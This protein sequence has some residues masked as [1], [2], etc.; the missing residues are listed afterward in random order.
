MIF[1]LKGIYALTIVVMLIFGVMKVSFFFVID[2]C[3]FCLQKQPHKRTYLPYLMTEEKVFLYLN[4]PKDYF[5][6]QNIKNV[7]LYISMCKHVSIL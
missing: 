6:C 3:T 1:E 5:E 7:D 4:G 2:K